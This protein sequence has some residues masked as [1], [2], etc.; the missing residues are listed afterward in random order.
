MTVESIFQYDRPPIP[1]LECTCMNGNADVQPR[2]HR[3]RKNR[4]FGTADPISRPR[5]RTTEAC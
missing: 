3:L 1:I 4:G 5:R 2:S